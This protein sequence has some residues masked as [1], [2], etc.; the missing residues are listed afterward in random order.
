VYELYHDDAA[1]AV[2]Q[3]GKAFQEWNQRIM[4]QLAAFSILFGGQPEAVLI[5]E[6][7]IFTR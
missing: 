4:P 2:H 1:F 6:S 5:R 3:Q 7:D